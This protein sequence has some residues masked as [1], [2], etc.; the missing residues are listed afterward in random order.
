MEFLNR[1]FCRKN[2][3]RRG[4]LE[5][6]QSHEVSSFI[7]S[8]VALAL[9]AQGKPA[10]FVRIEI[11]GEKKCLQIAEIEIMSGGKNIAKGGKASQ[12]TTRNGGDASKALDGDKSPAWGKGMTHTKENQPNPWWEVDLGSAQN[13]DTIGLWSRSGFSDRFGRLHAAVAR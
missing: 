12:S 5:A 3:R 6:S 8:L 1:L 4:D 10:R 9:A 13:V 2:T 11:P 7:L